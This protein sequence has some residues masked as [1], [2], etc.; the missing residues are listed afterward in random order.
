MAACD[1][2]EDPG[3]G[4]ALVQRE[5]LVEVAVGRRAAARPV[6]QRRRHGVVAG[7]G[8]APGHVLDVVVHPER[9]LDDD[10]RTRRAPFRHDL[11]EAHRSISGLEGDVSDLHDPLLPRRRQQPARASASA[12]GS[13]SC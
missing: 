9:L 5:H 8:E 13:R 11:V 6:E 4:Q 7:I 2:D 3:V 12:C 10:H 1:V